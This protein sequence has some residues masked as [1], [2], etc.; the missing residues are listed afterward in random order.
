MAVPH[1]MDAPFARSTEERLLTSSLAACEAHKVLFDASIH[2]T[3]TTKPDAG[4][5]PIEGVEVY[6]E[7][8]EPG[9]N[10]TLP[11]DGCTGNTTTTDGGAFHIMIQVDDPSLYGKNDDEIP[12]R[13]RYAKSTFTVDENSEEKEI[14]HE[15]LRNDGLEICNEEFGDIEF[16]THL[17]FEKHLEIYDDTSVPFSGRLTY[18]RTKSLDAPDGCPISEAVVCFTHNTTYGVE[19]DLVCVDS[20]QNGEFIAPVVI[21]GTLYAFNPT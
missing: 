20:D 19:A 5:L 21:G 3:V 9:S 6:W 14:K 15:F 12:I 10:I 17:E 13:I 8:L 2:G 18:S 16:I 1:Y 11:C 4:R 7:L